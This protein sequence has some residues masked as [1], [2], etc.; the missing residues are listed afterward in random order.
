[1]EGFEFYGMMHLGHL[2]PCCFSSDDT[3]GGGDEKRILNNE[4]QSHVDMCQGRS[5][6]RLFSHPDQ[7]H[8]QPRDVVNMGGEYSR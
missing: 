8:E 1:M 3:N 5:Q 7:Q 2:E 6:V 4:D